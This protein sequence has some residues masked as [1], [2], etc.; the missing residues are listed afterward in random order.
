MTARLLGWPEEDDRLDHVEDF[1]S[2]K[3]VGKAL[4]WLRACHESG[5]LERIYLAFVEEQSEPT[6]PARPEPEHEP[7]E[8]LW[9]R[10]KEETGYMDIAEQLVAAEAEAMG[11][12]R[13]RDPVVLKSV[14]MTLAHEKRKTA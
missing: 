10:I 7:T 12:P 14:L 2:A 3:N 6:T 5:D 9:S 1:L 4:P 11:D 8:W 13:R